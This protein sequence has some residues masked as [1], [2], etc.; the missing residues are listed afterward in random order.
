VPE[1]IQ[2]K[3]EAGKSICM[4]CIA[5]DNFA[6]VMKIVEPKKAKLAEAQKELDEANG[7]LKEKQARLQAVR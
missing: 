6:D 2:K 3:S 4:W 7:V 5:M 1:N